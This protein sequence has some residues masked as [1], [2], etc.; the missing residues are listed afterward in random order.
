VQPYE[1][2]W[3][4]LL[5][6]FSKGI[7][8]T[9]VLERDDGFVRPTLETAV[10]FSDYPQWFGSEQLAMEHVHGRVLDV[11]CGAGRHA[12]Y[13]QGRGHDVLAMDESPLAADVAMER[14]VNRTAIVSLARVTHH[15]G[16]FE[17][18][19][20]L[21]GG[22]GLFGSPSG[23]RRML[24]RFYKMTSSGARILAEGIDPYVTDDPDHLAYLERNR[25]RGRMP[26]QTRLRIRYRKLR[27]PWFDLLNVSREEM[28]EIVA[29][30]G[31]LVDRIIDEN[32][33]EYIA[34]IA[35]GDPLG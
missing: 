34:V 15:I 1:D 14:G 13:L 33:G 22:F 16:T 25:A 26:G 8:A 11:G 31:W 17:T 9:G 4:R 29:G 19:L 5:Q 6:D 21:C 7:A 3:G 10:F 24:R 30:T 2:A 27:T 28:T 20:M 12:L 23:A 18:I 32:A 35:R